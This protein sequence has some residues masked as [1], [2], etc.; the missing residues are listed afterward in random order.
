[1]AAETVNNSINSLLT[2]QDLHPFS[3][4]VNGIGGLC[5]TGGAG[6]PEKWCL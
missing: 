3:M 5:T 1:M 6:D 4:Y 2:E